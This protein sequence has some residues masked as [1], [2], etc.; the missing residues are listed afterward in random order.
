M[1]ISTIQQFH[2][3]LTGIQSG[4]K[5]LNALQEKIASGVKILSSS[6]DP[7]AST[8]IVKL[9]KEVSMTD[10]LQ[11]NIQFAKSRNEL[12]EGVLGSVDGVIQR[13]RELAVGAQNPTLNESDYKIIATE[14][15]QL[16]SEAAGLLNSKD[17]AGEHLYGGFQGREAPF[18]ERS[19]GGF[20][21]VGDEGQRF[22]QVGASMKIPV[23]D[24]GRSLFVDIASEQNTIIT[25]KGEINTGTADISTGRVIDQAA[26]DDV[27]PEDFLVTF[28]DPE[29]NQNRLT[30]TITQKSDGRNVLGD[31]PP[32]YLVNV[33][34]NEGDSIRFKGV[35]FFMS[36]TPKAGD[37]FSID[38][39]ANESLLNSI[40]RFAYA[41]ENFSP[42]EV[43][44]SE[45]ADVIGMAS[46]GKSNANLAGNYVAAQ[47]VTVAGL[48]GFSQSVNIT[49]GMQAPAVVAALN[50]LTGVT[51]SYSDT[52]ATIDL[53]GAQM[54]E[55][56]TISFTLNG[57]AISAV[58]GASNATT[59]ANVATAINTALGSGTFTVTD[60]TDGTI[61]LN[62]TTAQDVTIEDFAITDFPR[63]TLDIQS[64]FD[65]GDTISFTLT[66]TNGEVVPVS[67]VVATADNDELL[68]SLQAD[69]TAS[70]FGASFSLT[71][72]SAGAPLVLQYRGDVNGNASIDI[73]GFTDGGSDNAQLILNPFNGTTA[74]NAG[75][76]TAISTIYNGVDATISAVENRATV[77]FKGVIGNNITLLEGAG[78]SSR[79][80]ARISVT[81]LENYSV[82]SN[83]SRQMGGIV[84]ALK[85]VAS[86]VSNRFSQSI[87]TVLSNLAHSIENVSKGRAEIGARLNT[88]DSTEELNTDN[89]L[90][91]KRFLSVLRD[92]DYAEAITELKLQTFSLE[93]A[94][95]SFATISRLTLFNFI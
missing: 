4:Q 24:S 91:F 61:L 80:A 27:F 51:A 74:I 17:G 38:S 63:V 10:Q 23:S 46:P 84:S 32:G 78:D 53:N 21:Y 49:A 62:D 92:L 33:P 54:Y 85:N 60:N 7:I 47:S 71:Q 57:T 15:R 48:N 18:V 70:T 3:G 50:T 82:S 79:V 95:Q 20:D 29:L 39:T 6:D 90:E 81:T 1:R 36:G 13:V 89:L 19:T 2:T 86:V 88:I 16:L 37:T 76:Q 59:Y 65:V 67:Y 5:T 58:V 43:D 30:F 55:G 22:I 56:E 42:S 73:T 9:E 41:L 93:A 28:N 75:T 31:N 25:A 26:F 34:Y 8:Q 69:I 83:V 45:D 12:S 72:A 11:K 68:A 87:N 77:G 66:G 44:L 14:V 94:Q 52:Q 35:E 64:G 40:E